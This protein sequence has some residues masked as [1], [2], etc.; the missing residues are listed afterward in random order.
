[1]VS[2]LWLSGCSHSG[3]FRF[4]VTPRLNACPSHVYVAVV[5]THESV[6][7]VI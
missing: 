1:M 7:Y 4:E 3:W 5:S 6:G 2:P